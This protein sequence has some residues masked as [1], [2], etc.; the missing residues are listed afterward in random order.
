MGSSILN[1]FVSPADASLTTSLRRDCAFCFNMQRETT[2][3]GV[4]HCISM[5]SQLAIRPCQVIY[6]NI[7][8]RKGGFL[9]N[10]VI[11]L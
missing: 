9:I 1:N 2:S 11:N 6:I 5:L 3:T 10:Y 7:F 4:H 8:V